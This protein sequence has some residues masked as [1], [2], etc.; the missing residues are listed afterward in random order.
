MKKMDLL[1]KVVKR[2]K[3]DT[4]LDLLKLELSK[5]LKLYNS[6]QQRV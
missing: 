6:N 5:I 1:D 4:K 3:L 2:N